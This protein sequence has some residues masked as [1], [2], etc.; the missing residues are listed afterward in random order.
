M[1]HNGIAMVAW[2]ALIRKKQALRL[3]ATWG[4]H[5]RELGRVYEKGREGREGDEKGQ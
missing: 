1:D 5:P 2:A 4:T 3:G